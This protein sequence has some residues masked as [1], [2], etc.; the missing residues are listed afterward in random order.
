MFS[1]FA[2]EIRFLQYVGTRTG[3]MPNTIDHDSDASSEGLELNQYESTDWVKLR[4][5]VRW[6]AK[7]V[8]IGTRLLISSSKN[9][10][11]N[12]LLDCGC[13]LMLRKSAYKN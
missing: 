8:I 2:D 4:G 10:M 9:D 11:T 6:P 5:S 13:L 3:Y 12:R 1:I 7:T